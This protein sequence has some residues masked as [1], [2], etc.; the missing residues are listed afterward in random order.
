AVSASRP[1]ME[2]SVKAAARS[3]SKAKKAKAQRYK[4]IYHE[5]PRRP[6]RHTKN[7]AHD[8][9]RQER[10]RSWY[11]KMTSASG[12][13]RC[14]FYGVLAMKCSKQPTVTM[15]SECSPNEPG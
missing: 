14:A 1:V 9:C 11:W 4:S 6:R 12:T 13:S 3:V 15:L 10:K 2:S 7:R 5:W 8:C